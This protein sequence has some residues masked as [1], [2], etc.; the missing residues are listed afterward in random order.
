MSTAD[1]RLWEL[2]TQAARHV[3]DEVTGR[4]DNKALVDELRGRLTDKDL[5]AHVREV[6]IDRLAKSLADG[7]VK[8]RNPKP[9]NPAGLFHPEAIL[10]LGKGKRIWM[11]YATDKDLIEWARQSTRNLAQ[12][13]SAEGARQ[14]YVSERLDAF[15]M[16]REW[17]LG[18]IERE[19]FGYV[20]VEEPPDYS[21]LETDEDE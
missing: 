2:V 19:V 5:M 9:G 15:R 20:D 7:F 11:E 17:K 3:T 8:K 18:R 16:H 4:F 21:D 13:A 10:P 6:S 12:V 14:K 1:A